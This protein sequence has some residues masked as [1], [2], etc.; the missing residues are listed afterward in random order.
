MTDATKPIGGLL[1][2]AVTTIEFGG[3]FLLSILL[4]A[5]ISGLTEFQRS[6]FRVGH[7]HAGVL[8]I[9]ALV[10]LAFTATGQF[11]PAVLALLLPLK[12]R[13]FGVKHRFS[14][15]GRVS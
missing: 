10:A 5:N 1:L 9:L 7:T 6:K 15:A 12:Q 8:V 13:R 14:L 4:R 11:S 2:I 3:T